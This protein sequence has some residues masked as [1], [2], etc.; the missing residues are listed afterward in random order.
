M[1]GALPE[2]LGG[3]VVLLGVPVKRPLCGE[4]L[5]VVAI[6]KGADVIR[7]EAALL[8]AHVAWLVAQRP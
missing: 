4:S 2:G 7:P 6:A 8:A 5:E 1:A 3:E